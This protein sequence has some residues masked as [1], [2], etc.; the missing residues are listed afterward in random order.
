MPKRK[1]GQAQSLS[2][3]APKKRRGRPSNSPPS[4]PAQHP[5]GDIDADR[6]YKLRNILNE[7]STHYLIDWED[8][9]ETGESFDPSWEPKENANPE[10][11]ADWE[12]VK[13]AKSA[14][15]R[16]ASAS[17]AVEGASAPSNKRLKRGRLRKRVVESSP[18][19]VFTAR[20]DEDDDEEA[21]PVAIWEPEAEQELLEIGESQHATAGAEREVT[22]NQSPLFVSR[23]VSPVPSRKSP[24]ASA[25]VQV[26]DPPSSFAAGDYERFSLSQRKG[27]EGSQS[28]GDSA[29][30]FQNRGEAA[31][32]TSTSATAAEPHAQEK[33]E[34]SQQPINTA[35][36]N[37]SNAITDSSTSGIV[38]QQERKS[39]EPSQYIPDHADTSKE[40]TDTS[41]NPTTPSQQ[42][43]T[44]LEVGETVVTTVPDSQSLPD[45]QSFV[46][47]STQGETSGETSGENQ[48][49]GTLSEEQI[50][51][52]NIQA[53][54]VEAAPSTQRVQESSQ[55]V[56]VPP[57]LFENS[58]RSQD[59]RETSDKQQPSQQV[60]PRSTA[61]EIDD[62]FAG[63][64]SST[65]PADL[66]KP[67]SQQESHSGLIET[68]TAKEPGQQSSEEGAENA[69]G[70]R[71]EEERPTVP[72][73]QSQQSDSQDLYRTSVPP[74]QR[75]RSPQTQ[76]EP[77]SQE[78]HSSTQQENREPLKDPPAPWGF[79]RQ[80]H[81]RDSD[82]APTASSDQTVASVQSD[83]A[84]TSFQKQNDSQALDVSNLQRNSD[85]NPISISSGQP[86]SSESINERIAA[87]IASGTVSGPHSQAVPPEPEQQKS[88]EVTRQHL[89]SQSQ[90]ANYA[91]A[92]DIN[93]RQ[94]NRQDDQS[95]G[96]EDNTDSSAFP[97]ITQIGVHHGETPAERRALFLGRNHQP[98]PFARQ[99]KQHPPS[100]I[101]LHGSSQPQPAAGSSIQLSS[102]F[103]SFPT[104]SPP[105]FGESAPPRPQTPSTP[106]LE[107]MQ[108]SPQTGEPKLSLT[109]KINRMREARRS[110]TQARL[111][112][113]PNA[114]AQTPS[115][116]VRPNAVPERLTSPAPSALP[117]RLTSPAPA[118]G[119]RSPSAVPVMEPL[120]V[121]SQED[122]TT[123]ERYYTLLPEAHG[124]GEDT[125]IR[126]G[127][128]TFQQNFDTTDTTMAEPEPQSGS[129]FHVVPIAMIGHQRDHY[130]Q[131]VYYGKELVK[132]F[133]ATEAPDEALM[134]EAEE[135]VMRIK[136]IVNH[137]DLDNREAMTQ[138]DVSPEQQAEWSIHCSAKFKF[139]SELISGFKAKYPSSDFKVVLL[140]SSSVLATMLFN[141]CKTLPAHTHLELDEEE[142]ESQ[143]EGSG[144]I[145]V[146]VSSVPEPQC[147]KTDGADL[148]IAFDDG[149]EDVSVVRQLD[150]Y[151]LRRD[152]RLVLQLVVPRSVEHI[153]R[154]LAPSLSARARL[155]ALL[156]GIFRLRS[157]AGRLEEDQVPPKEAAAAIVDYMLADGEASAEWPLATL[158]RLDQ[159]DSQTESELE[160]QT[161]E[162][163]GSA[164]SQ[165]M[166]HTG[167]K[168]GFDTANMGVMDSDPNKRARTDM[169]SVTNNAA[170]PV[171]INPAE[172]DIT[173]VSDSV[174]KPTQGNLLT[175]SIPP[176]PSDTERRLRKLL[177][178]T[179]DRLD[180][181]VKAMSEL[182]YR[183][184]DQRNEMVEACT[185]R[186]NITE[187]AARAMNRVQEQDEV[188]KALRIERN[189]LKTKLLEAD[190]RLLSHSV[191]ER[192]EL[193]AL[194]IAK[195]K[196]Q[197]ETERL[198][199]RLESANGELE[200]MRTMYQD[201]SSK[202][203]A[204]AQQNGQLENELAIAQNK[205]TGTQVALKQMSQDTLTKRLRA[206]NKKLAAAIANREAGLKTRDEEI[207][208]LKEASRGRMG[209]RATSVPRSPRLGSPLKAATSGS[210]G[211]G[212]SASR[213]GSPSASELRG[214]A[215]PG[216]HPLRNG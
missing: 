42:I 22:G 35:T 30:T 212:G 190:E 72:E 43:Q 191:P 102:P 23:D 103:P 79:F 149:L 176:F 145:T 205:A 73:K 60:P 134:Q 120:P 198:Q 111:G 40:T 101:P 64:I 84:P 192:A 68:E 154:R 45:S 159:L 11:V 47:K 167:V 177:K 48:L 5:H 3:T 63:A 98:F 108:S 4:P 200:Y 115:E 195:D 146:H 9:T 162:I 137:P 121:I 94:I 147:I 139:L 15:R 201:T 93:G 153:E 199:T 112:E 178:E 207:A 136:R 89:P 16:I 118:E 157:E 184:E 152:I 92:A 189:E 85:R 130:P 105:T 164:E 37:N 62:F 7:T 24:R 140:A 182:Q 59:S 117:A 66:H 161:S 107:N 151:A 6:E 28:V 44:E 203:Q 31:L 34:Q 91:A 2:S 51:T 54:E 119:A 88:V 90:G 163:V 19:P 36:A 21:A 125:R 77:Q 53:S 138:Y 32:D 131:T 61:D 97:F 104:H 208:R 141:H 80:F 193:E 46:P 174:D 67:A 69:V 58:A 156:S 116:P 150:G 74:R 173:H 211:N 17:P 26:S 172:L 106:D 165:E 29:Q 39:P 132:R 100:D 14:S 210:G 38:V 10:A 99:Q 113:T 8:D 185:D 209:T 124:N 213:Q 75:S 18:E 126:N 1:R 27:H 135:F 12:N 57:T 87:S 202:A 52:Q 181:H 187:S 41:A 71:S 123:S 129:K 158:S 148:L 214:R 194:R 33:P 170:M 96:S 160:P 114:A 155:H 216:L 171:T 86:T 206:E 76:T 50:A 144:N 197:A 109:A 95:R 168:R 133:T 183:H 82:K 127:N 20:R 83:P 56:N 143:I 215:G 78:S 128:S 110:E 55:V 166:A 49:K 186:D 180:E 13:A 179:Q 204:L 169:A 65:N 175:S 25:T 142:H 196:A 188:L 122:Q 81:N 70:D